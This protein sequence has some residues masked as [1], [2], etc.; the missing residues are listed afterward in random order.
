MAVKY[1][2]IYQH[3]P[4]QDP[5]EF[6]H[7]GIFGMKTN[8]PAILGLWRYGAVGIGFKPRQDIRFLGK[9]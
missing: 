7:F 6:T 1:S 9:T 4:F 5:P 8:H 2:N 3:F